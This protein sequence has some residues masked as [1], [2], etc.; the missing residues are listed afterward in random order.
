MA[1][2]AACVYLVLFLQDRDG[3][4]EDSA[5]LSSGIIAARSQT[6][7]MAVAHVWQSNRSS[8]P[9]PSSSFSIV[10]ISSF[11]AIG[12]IMDGLIQ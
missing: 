8:R 11:S 10:A 9:K 1:G 12:L 2:K 4:I 6:L 5:F 7:M 3:E